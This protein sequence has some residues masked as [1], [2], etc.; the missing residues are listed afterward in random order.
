M[1]PAMADPLGY[2]MTQANFKEGVDK[3]GDMAIVLAN[4][5]L[6][7]EPPPVMVLIPVTD[8]QK[9]IAN[10]SRAQKEG[11]LDK[12]KMSFAGEPGDEDTYATNWG[13]Y[14]VLTP[15]KE[16]LSKK[17]DGFKP[18]AGAA[19]EI[20]SKDVVVLANMK[21]L[22]PL[23]KKEIE[24]H[25]DEVNG[26]IDSGLVQNPDAQPYAPVLKTLFGQSVNA[27][28]RFLTETESAV[29]SIDL[30]K[31]GMDSACS[32]IFLPIPTSG[33][34]SPRSRGPM[35]RSSKDCRPE[36]I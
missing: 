5:N 34:A 26:Q 32:P 12:F 11:E 24:S 4:G 35:P 8:Y 20:E 33:K 7:A 23:A 30:Q 29:L 19:K 17:P 10:F 28:E 13:H 22:G 27:A 21:L 18:S 36:S 6:Q 1:N 3:S 9:F 15:T 14:A 2:L 25:K 16:L 31:E